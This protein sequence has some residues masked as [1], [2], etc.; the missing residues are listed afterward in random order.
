MPDYD[1]RRNKAT[2]SGDGRTRLIKG[3]KGNGGCHCVPTSLADLIGYYAHKGVNVRPGAYPWWTRTVFDG[4]PDEDNDNPSQYLGLQPY[5]DDE[6][7][8]YRRVTNLI[9]DLGGSVKTGEDGCGTSYGAVVDSFEEVVEGGGFN[10]ALLNF[11][12]TDTG[13]FAGRAIASVMY[14]GGLV[15]VAFG[16]Y[17]DYERDGSEVN[18]GE[19]ATG[20]AL[21]VSAIAGNLSTFGLTY[22]DPNSKGDRWRQANFRPVIRDIR[23]L[24]DVNAIGS[25]DWF[26]RLGPDSG[27]E[28]QALIDQYIAVYPVILVAGQGNQLKV[29]FG[30]NLN[31]LDG[32]VVH[33]AA[34]PTI[35]KI[36]L[37]G[38]LVKAVVLPLTG[39][40]AYLTENSRKIMAM[41]PGTGDRRVLGH[42]PAGAIDLEAS[43]TGKYV[44]ALGERTVATFE[45][46]EGMVANA[47]V[48]GRPSALAYDW[49]QD[50]PWKQG[51]AVISEKGRRLTVLDPLSL[52]ERRSERLPGRVFAGEGRLTATFDQNGR[53]QVRK[54]DD[55]LITD[56]GARITTRDGK[57]VAGRLPLDGLRLGH[58]RLLAISHSGADFTRAERNR[59]IDEADPKT[60]P[61]FDEPD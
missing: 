46:D 40:I 31:R 57:L 45:R 50:E 54:G 8:A 43:P 6:I 56:A 26:Y 38:K 27:G 4:N 16:R 44:F 48:R 22:N 19:R 21:A 5:P 1:Q 60:G 12:M 18:V 34:T 37:P 41:V 52:K 3:L 14:N 49:S 7:A 42:A 29:V 11:G 20:H 61:P 33:T 30:F 59:F 24:R 35:T 13:E 25:D 47:P 39:E 36:Q 55:V 2:V 28:K 9:R 32:E 17:K 58:V 15:G 23:R 10:N 51:L 53:L